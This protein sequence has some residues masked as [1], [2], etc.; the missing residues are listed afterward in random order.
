MPKWTAE[1]LILKLREMDPK[2]I[3]TLCYPK[4]WDVI[5]ATNIHVDSDMDDNDEPIVIFRSPGA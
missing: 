5:E 2:S 1:E 4:G 3:V